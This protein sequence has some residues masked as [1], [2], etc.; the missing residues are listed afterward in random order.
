MQ[1]LRIHNDVPFKR[2]VIQRCNVRNFDRSVGCDH[3]LVLKKKR[4]SNLFSSSQ[5]KGYKKGK[6]KKEKKSIVKMKEQ[7]TLKTIHWPKRNPIFPSVWCS[8][9]FFILFYFCLF[10]DS[11]SFFFMYG[12]NNA[13]LFVYLVSFL[14]FSPFP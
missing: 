4:T 6:G 14:F 1:R 10:Y 2:L 5:S 8:Q 13:F 11:F 12:K 3:V 7:K 9:L